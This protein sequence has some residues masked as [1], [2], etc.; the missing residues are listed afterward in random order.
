MTALQVP[1]H[2]QYEIPD[3]GGANIED[4]EGTVLMTAEDIDAIIAPRSSPAPSARGM[5]AFGQMSHKG[6]AALRPAAMPASYRPPAG[7]SAGAQGQAGPAL[8]HSATSQ[9]VQVNVCDAA[10]DVR[11]ACFLTTAYRGA[12]AHYKAFTD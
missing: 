5:Q 11:V 1:Q 12:A 2:I 4:M 7:P 8:G 9:T 6:S 3:L 10:G